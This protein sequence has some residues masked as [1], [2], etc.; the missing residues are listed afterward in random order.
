[1]AAA[2]AFFCYLRLW[3]IGDKFVC[4]NVCWGC[5]VRD[6]GCLCAC[7]GLHFVRVLS[8][9]IP[10]VTL[11]S[12]DSRGEAAP[13]VSAAVSSEEIWRRRFLPSMTKP[14]VI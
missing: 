5:V 4:V 10:A 7:P 1:M 8:R 6:R 12:S 9:R 11:Q 13:C 2:S 3:G 14:D